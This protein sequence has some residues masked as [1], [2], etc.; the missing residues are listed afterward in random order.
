MKKDNLTEG[1]R[2]QSKREWAAEKGFNSILSVLLLF[3]S[4]I[5]LLNVSILLMDQMD[6]LF[7]NL[8]KI[9]TALHS[10]VTRYILIDLR[11]AE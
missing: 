6:V 3:V 9:Q 5:F 11:K 1:S 2:F 4:D 8:T 10:N 7:T